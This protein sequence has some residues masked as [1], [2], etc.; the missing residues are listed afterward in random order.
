MN[1]KTAQALYL[2]GFRKAN[3]ITRYSGGASA[4]LARATKGNSKCALKV[5]HLEWREVVRHLDGAERFD[6]LFS[7][8]QETLA[9]VPAEVGG[10][11]ATIDKGAKYYNVS[12]NGICKQVSEICGADSTRI[13]LKPD[14][15][16]EG[17]VMFR[18]QRGL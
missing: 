8:A 12:V 14:Y 4:Y 10:N 16:L 9:L 3:N 17:V 5:H 7:E 11:K 2:M 13:E 6:Y 1:D 15:S 18:I